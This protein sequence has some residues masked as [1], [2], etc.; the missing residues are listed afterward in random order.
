MKKFI[1]FYLLIIT[2]SAFG[3]VSDINKT[4]GWYM[5]NECFQGQVDVTQTPYTGAELDLTLF[6]GF[7][8]SPEYYGGPYQG[9]YLFCDLDN[10]GFNNFFRTMYKSPWPNEDRGIIVHSRRGLTTEDYTVRYGLTEPRKEVVTDFNNDGIKEVLLFSQGLDTDPF[11]GDSIMLY[12]IDGDSVQYFDNVSFYHSGTVGDIDNDGDQDIITGH[13]QTIDTKI[14]RIPEVYINMGDFKF[15]HNNSMFLNFPSYE[16]YPNVIDWFSTELYDIDDD[17]FLDFIGSGI[18]S[19]DQPHLVV[20]FQDNGVFD[21]DKKIII[22]LEDYGYT[23]V[24]DIDFYD[25]DN[26]GNTEILLNFTPDYVTHKPLM[27]TT[28]DRR[29]E[30]VT[31]SYFLNDDID[32]IWFLWHFLKDIDGDGD[33][34][35]IPDGAQWRYFYL[36]N[37]NGVFQKVDSTPITSSNS[38]NGGDGDDSGSAP[39]TPTIVSPTQ[40][41]DSVT[42]PTQFIWEA[43]D[44]TTSYEVELFTDALNTTVFKQSLTDTSM[45]YTEMIA[46]KDYLF[47]V[48]A[49]NDAGTSRWSS[50]EFRTEQKNVNTSI[51][52]SAVPTTYSLQQNYP[53]P[54]NPT[55]TI[56]FSLKNGGYVNL[57]VFDVL[58]KEILT[59]FEG[60]LL[61]GNHSYVVDGSNLKSGTYFYKLQTSNY[62]LIKQMTLIK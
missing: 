24:V 58:G 38:N 42:I 55:T 22:D 41:A 40:N 5:T 36:E 26:D 56:S 45:V 49:I 57:K 6:S 15:E 28:S 53:N 34:D 59:V 44:N 35:I 54:F 19:N 16:F 33:I 11:P 14:Q 7:T 43:D 3:Q 61:S 12:H 30:D 31:S 21:Y 4:T 52:N 9:Y 13:R 27:F 50:V 2:T 29:F 48:R 18:D 20:I 8:N 47:R 23:G 51:L 10:D 62:N 32:D 37:N 46:D 60:N 1:L 39:S 17:G 25:F